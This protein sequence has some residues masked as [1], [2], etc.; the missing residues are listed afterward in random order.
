M[1][2]ATDEPPRL[3]ENHT[4]RWPSGSLSAHVEEA[5]W[6]LE[7][8]HVYMEENG[9]SQEQLENMR[10]SLERMKRGLDLLKKPTEIVRKGV[11][12]TKRIFL[13]KFGK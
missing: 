12:K 13:E 8:N 6:L 1:V 11:Q 5:I 10:S 7:Q 4:A 2:H 9:V 3:A